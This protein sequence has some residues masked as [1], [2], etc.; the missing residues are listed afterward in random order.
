MVK[1]AGFNHP[2]KRLVTLPELMPLAMVAPEARLAPTGEVPAPRKA[3]PPFE[4]RIE[5]GRDD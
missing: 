2:F 3:L 5:N 4:S 1:A